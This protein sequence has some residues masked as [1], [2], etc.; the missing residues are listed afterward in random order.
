MAELQYPDS[1]EAR[2]SYL[3]HPRSQVCGLDWLF[4]FDGL[5][6]PVILR[7][8]LVPRESDATRSEVGFDFVS[9][10]PL[11]LINPREEWLNIPC[12]YGDVVLF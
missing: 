5:E 3:K 6:E 8:H 4:M 2:C 10:L 9:V 12:A 11:R 7:P 1:L